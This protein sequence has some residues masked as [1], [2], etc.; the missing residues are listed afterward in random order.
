[1]A[2][3]RAPAQLDG[4]GAPS[5]PLSAGPARGANADRWADA[6]LAALLLALHPQGLGGVRLQGPPDERREHWLQRLRSSCTATTPWLRLPLHTDDDRLL[7]GL[8]LGAT[9]QRG[10]VVAQPGLLARG[11]GGFVLAVMA[12][13]MSP[14]MAA[15]LCAVLD[16]GTV[17]AQRPGATASTSARVA[18]VALDEAPGSD[19]HADAATAESPPAALLERLGLWVDLAP[20]PGAAAGGESIDALRLDAARQRLPAVCCSDDLLQA[21]CGAA[22]ALGVPSLRA[23]LFGLAAARAHA[24]WCGRLEVAVEDVAVAARL[25]LAPRATQLPMAP[26]EG[27]ADAHEDT[28]EAAPAASAETPPPA[29]A[30]DPAAAG[31]HQPPPAE[32]EGPAP[33]PPAEQAATPRD[34]TA[35]TSAEQVLQSALAAVP[36]GLLQLLA[37]AASRGPAAPGGRA[38]ALQA[39]RLRGRPYGSRRGDPRG[40]ARL[41]LIDTLR[42]AAPWQMLRQREAA[43][44]ASSAS[45]GA[46]A[47]AGAAQ[48]RVQVRREDFHVSRFRQRRETTTVFVVDASGSAALHRLAEAK[49]AVELLLAECYVRRDRVALLSFRG[50]VGAELLLPPTRSLVRA[51]RCLAGLPGGGGT[52]LAA[53]LDAARD[54]TQDIVRRGGT[55]LAVFLTDGRANIARDGSPGR[56]RAHA[57]AEAAALAWRA[58][59]LGAVWLDTATHPQ[60]QARALAQAMGARYLPLPHADARQMSRAVMALR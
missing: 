9:L 6:H 47:A 18:V 44:A 24:A 39:S 22:L 10:T 26:D 36:A 11:D 55:P 29:A 60:P 3:P 19:Q 20:L 23:A 4:S 33:E 5:I 30:A 28:A 40:G 37:A 8:D 57:D 49:G 41:H 12:E 34:P 2:P 14:A 17:S 27:D 48:P 13:R 1:M 50:T 54:L 35:T 31:A 46:A 52:P 53:A 25:V 38:G 56:A 21:L 42:A 7:G 59:G 15:R 16:T 43:S 51:K 58:A 45:S 32:P